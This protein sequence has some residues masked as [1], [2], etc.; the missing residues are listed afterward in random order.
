[1]HFKGTRRTKRGDD[2]ECIAPFPSVNALRVRARPTSSP[3]A[4]SAHF[5]AN[6]VP[7]GPRRHLQ[8]TDL[9]AVP[10]ARRQARRRVA[11][12]PGGVSARLAGP[13]PHAAQRAGSHGPP[14]AVGARERMDRRAQS[15]RASD[16]RA[17]PA[18]REQGVPPRRCQSH[19]SCVMVEGGSSMPRL[20]LSLKRR[21]HEVG[22]TRSHLPEGR[23]RP[24]RTHREF[25]RRPRLP[26]PP[27]RRPPYIEAAITGAAFIFLLY[28][29]LGGA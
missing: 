16:A 24:A 13:S 4:A 29:V 26:D 28:L 21:T 18:I 12:D 2:G 17:T 1:M 10:A 11:I 14:L 9:A 20:Q 23:T 19:V 25:G 3:P 6:A 27:V 5:A 8:G 15:H 22:R 7:W